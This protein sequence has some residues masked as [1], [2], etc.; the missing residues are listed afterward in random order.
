[1]A[2][3]D[4]WCPSCRWQGVWDDV[5]CPECGE[6]TKSIEWSKCELVGFY[7]KT[8]EIEVTE[9]GCKCGQHGPGVY[10]APAQQFLDKGLR[11]GDEFWIVAN[12]DGLPGQILT[13]AEKSKRE[14]P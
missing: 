7:A 5:I 3:P 1:M 10:E 12:L 6:V 8:A 9:S 4:A 11:V 13:T 2:A 14:K